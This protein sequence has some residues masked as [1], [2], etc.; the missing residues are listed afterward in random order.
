MDTAGGDY[1]WPT[2]AYCYCTT[3]NR[4]GLSRCGCSE[5]ELWPTSEVMPNGLSV[6]ATAGTLGRF[7]IDPSEK[8][9]PGTQRRDQGN[10]SECTYDPGSYVYSPKALVSLFPAHPE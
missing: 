5:M 6:L 9:P 7:G 2:Q 3:S 8:C 4:S 1:A 10:R